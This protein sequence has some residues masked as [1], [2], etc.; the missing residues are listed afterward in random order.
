MKKIYLLFLILFAFTTSVTV[1]QSSHDKISYQSVVRDGSNHLLYDAQV[2]VA[3]SIKNSG[4]AAVKYSET[5]TVT[6]NA[7]GLISFLIGDGNSPSGNWD[8]VQWN[9]AEITLVTSVNGNVLSTHTYPLSAVPYAL[10]AKNADTAIYADSV[11]LTV[12]QNFIQS[13]GYLTDELQVLSISNDTIY[14]SKGGWV[15]LPAGFSG[16]YNDLT[17]K[18]DLKPVATS[19]DY[20]DLVNKPENLVQDANYVHTDNNYTTAEKNKLAGI[21]AGA[22]VNVQSDWE[23][24]DQSADDFIK[25][26]PDLSQYAT[27]NALR[28]TA[29]NIRSALVDTA[30]DIRDALV[31]TAAAIRAD[32][33]DAANDAKITIQKN[34]QNVGDFTLNQATDDTINILVPTK[35]TDLED[36]GNYVTKAKLNETLGAYYDTTLTKE[37]IHDTADVLRGEFPVVNNGQINIAVNRGTVTNS[38]FTVNQDGEQTVTINIPDEVIVNDGKLTLIKSAGD[39][40]LL[41]TANQSGND[42]LDLSGYFDTTHVK[43]AINDSLTKSVELTIKSDSL[44]L[45]S[46]SDMDTVKL[47]AAPTQVQ[48]N[49][50]EA[51]TSSAAYILNKPNIR[52]SVNKVVKDSLMLGTTAIN[53]AVD[54]IAA[55][56]AGHAIHD[57][58]VHNISSQ[59]HDTVMHALQGYDI[60]NCDDVNDCVTPVLGNYVLKTAV[61]DSVNNAVADALKDPVSAI[62]HAVDTIAAN[63]AGHAIHDSLTQ[64]VELTIKS[65]SLF[66][67]SGSDMDTVKLP[68]VPT[69]VQSNWKETNTSSAAFIQNKPNIRDSVNKVV[70]DSLMVGT[71]AINIA[72]DTI[73]RNN[74]HDTA[75]VI[76]NSLKDTVN[77]Y[78]GTK[79]LTIKQGTNTLGTFNANQSDN[80]VEVNIPVPDAQAQSNWKETN[81]S[82]AAFIQNKPNIRDSVNKVVKDSLM[83]GTSAINIAIDTIAR[84][85][86]HDTAVAIRNSIGDGMLT[87]Q[88]NG[89]AVG[90]SF[91]ANQKTDQ[92]VDIEVPTKL[93]QLVN[94]GAVYAK[95]DSVNVFTDVNNFTSTVTVPSNATTIPRPTTAAHPCTDNTANAVNVC[96]LLAVFDSLTNKMNDILKTI[97]TLKHINDSLAQEL[98]ALK[99]SLTVT[100]PSDVQYLCNGSNTITFTA[101]LTNANSGDYSYTWTVNGAVQTS[102]NTTMYYIPNATGDYKV[103]CTATRSGYTTLKDST[104]VNVS[105]GGYMPKFGI[106]QEGRTVTVKIIEDLLT[107]TVVWG[108]GEESVVTTEDS[109]EYDNGNYTIIAS[110]TAFGNCKLSWPITITETTPNPCTVST[111]HTNTST[112]T[113][114]TGGLESLENGKVVSVQDQDGH[115]YYVVQIGNQCWMRT[116][117]RT[118]KYNDG[119]TIPGGKNCSSYSTTDPYHYINPSYDPNYGYFYNWPAASNQICPKGWHV[120]SQEEWAT[121]FAEAGVSTTKNTGT[122][123]V[124]LAGGCDWEG[125]TLGTSSVTPNSYENQARDK[126]GF[127]AL[128]TG[129]C[130]LNNTTDLM[131][132][133]YGR[134]AYFWSSTEVDAQY[135]YDWYLG[136]GYSGAANEGLGK[137]HGRVVRCLRNEDAGSGGSTTQTDPSVT[138]GEAASVG[139]ATATL[140]ATIT[141][142]D[143]VEITDKGF[144]YK[145]TSDNSYTS[146]SGTGTGN[147]FTAD[148][149]GLD[150]GTDY[151]YHAFI[152]SASETVTGSEKT[153]TTTSTDPS[154]CTTPPTFTTCENG[155]IVNI[156]SVDHATS[157]SWG[158]D[159]IENAPSTSSSHTYGADGVYTITA[160]STPGCTATKQVAMGIATLHPCTGLTAHQTG[161][162]GNGYNGVVNDGY[163]ETNAEGI[164]SVTD[165]DGNVY[166]VVQIGSQ[167]WLAE[168]M[169]CTHSPKGNGNLYI[170]NRENLS[171]NHATVSTYSKAAHWYM[172]DST[173]YSMFGLLYNWCAAVDTFYSEGGK[174][175]IATA[176]QNFVYDDYWEEYDG[177]TE[178][179][180]NANF[181]ENVIRRGI[182]PKG[183]H[184]PNLNEFLS[185]MAAVTGSTVDY[186]PSKT[187][188]EWTQSGK[189]AKGC[190]WWVYDDEYES[191]SPSDFLNNNRNSMGFG[192]LPAGYFGWYEDEND[193][194]NSTFYDTYQVY[195]RFWSSTEKQGTTN[196]GIPFMLTFSTDIENVVV[197]SRD[198]KDNGHSVRCVRDAE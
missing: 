80:D 66:L 62:N 196:E 77:H 149:T 116:N 189:L 140:I 10:Y 46:G 45:K 18:P 35:V 8:A 90:T 20:N 132:E 167:C 118:S 56:I 3:V 171:G 163:E 172:N 43:K 31:D 61:R 112:Y 72:I 13:S 114:T 37:A 98:E 97:D 130:W 115:S 22:E 104:T 123:A 141:N 136:A 198:T 85:N 191:N 194:V 179:G 95:R 57:S 14:L 74:I 137:E 47:P 128:P 24:D 15:K 92:T 157:I 170:V 29:G 81:T 82:S 53:K 165:Y 78:I 152:T 38:S 117:L 51:N 153:F 76:R 192:G 120:P 181:G 99:P 113:P 32:M 146:V 182:C 58:I 41:F 127:T 6:S 21:E 166:P 161:Y 139:T 63:I 148:L 106:C 36:A 109:H 142:P 28:D 68:A 122:G 183:W 160:T 39:T 124:Y 100:G 145:R 48:S 12:V 2:T 103:I 64:N 174:S 50:K 30:S 44:F 121:L 186:E 73:A 190:D 178:Y 60:K 7:N 11:N 27:K 107:T 193:G 150:A 129:R 173:T 180:W 144:E 177:P 26:K 131:F 67:K 156:T 168:N 71:S 143:N 185:L 111:P 79:T 147:S 88:R 134:G 169:R 105:S 54:T 176:S 125:I 101:S 83:V 110:S 55:N 89:V 187:L 34:G 133:D 70:K 16:D 151:T 93:S 84:N 86:I 96:D 159:V 9:R 188:Y 59:I 154:P 87:I 25:N 75:T 162:T 4:D 158:D 42:T 33:G 184:V 49:W 94:D 40:T 197:Q 119:T 108:D 155:L 195:A 135:A 19:G 91:T 65:D 5:H 138:T 69:Q 164:I 175:E 23:Q 102:T 1:A 126:W 52:D 17:N